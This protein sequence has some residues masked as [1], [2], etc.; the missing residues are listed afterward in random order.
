VF[1]PDSIDRAE[2]G[3]VTVEAGALEA[4]A[5]VRLLPRLPWVED[6]ETVEVGSKPAHW[7]GAGNRFS[8]KQ[9]EGNRVLTKPFVKSG[10]QRS[11]VYIGK[12]DMSGYTVS[13]DLLG[14]KQGR[15]VPDMG[16]V[17]NRY[18]MGLMG[19]RQEIQIHS[20]VS[21]LRMAQSVPFKWEPNTWYTMKMRVDIEGGAAIVRG[22]VW[23]KGEP[24]PETWTIETR[25][26]LPNRQG[27]PGI[28]GQSY[29]EIYYDNLKVTKN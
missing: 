16:L 5:R 17:A 2:T 24:E 26:P 23:R 22:K 1:R 21:E 15:R 4:S 27:T 9:L 6:F 13:A 3:S 29:A 7:I 8:V 18:A 28:F 25:D 19:L 12:S 10:I 20:W 14:N 11:Y